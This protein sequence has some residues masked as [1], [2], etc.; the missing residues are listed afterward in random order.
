MTCTNT[1][2]ES[3]Q[4]RLD[5]PTCYE[6]GSLESFDLTIAEESGSALSS[7]QIVF[8][9]SDSDTAALTLANG[10]GLTLTSTTA[11]AWIIT[12]DQINTIT[13]SPG[14][15][16]YNLKTVDVSSRTKF[17]LAGNWTIKNV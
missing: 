2:C 5:F 3:E 14:V 11:G 6:G 16:F 12:I 4:G 17:Y 10:S 9:A 8:K 13:L 15:Y 1:C 7:A